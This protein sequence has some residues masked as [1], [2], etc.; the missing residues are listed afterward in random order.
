MVREALALTIDEGNAVGDERR[1]AG[2]KQMIA[3]V[4][5]GV[6]VVSGLTSALFDQY[7]PSRPRRKLTVWASPRSSRDL[8]LE[9]PCSNM[10]MLLKEVTLTIHADTRRS[11]HIPIESELWFAQS[12]RSVSLVSAFILVARP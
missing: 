2:K 3:S 10:P 8:R 7:A 9:C 4:V 11:H 12:A 1:N 6:T 5:V